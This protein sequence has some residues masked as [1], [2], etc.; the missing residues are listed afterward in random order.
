MAAL[1]SA[2]RGAQLR[3]HSLNECDTVAMIATPAQI[4]ATSTQLPLDGVGWP[5]CLSLSK[6]E[7]TRDPQCTIMPVNA[8]AT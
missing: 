7:K 1:L 5:F 8:R 3:A 6:L 4:P 2:V